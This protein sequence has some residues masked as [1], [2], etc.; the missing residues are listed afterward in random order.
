MHLPTIHPSIA[1]LWIASLAGAFWAGGE[2]MK[3]AGR[4][5][6]ETPPVAV[7]MLPAATS[8]NE[9]KQESSSV[10]V[11]AP[12]DPTGTLE[13]IAKA[14]RE[15]GPGSEAMH[16]PSTM[17]RTM[18]PLMDLPVSEILPALEEVAA[19]VEDP[20]QRAKL[21]SLLLGRWA[22]EDPLSALAY[23][24]KWVDE[25]DYAGTYSLASVVSTWANRDPDALWEWYAKRKESQSLP[26]GMHGMDGLT[27]PLEAIFS[28]TALRDPDLA[29]KQLSQLDDEGS[30]QA[31]LEGISMTVTDRQTWKAIL[32]GATTLEPE[33]RLKL[34]QSVLPQWAGAEPD[35]AI[36]WMRALP[37]DERAPLLDMIDYDLVKALPEKGADFLIENSDAPTLP[38]RYAT[39]ISAWASKDPAA[40]AE[41]LNRQPKSPAQDQARAT[42]AYAIMERDPESAMEW[43]KSISNESRRIESI[44]Q[45]YVW[46]HIGDA[47]AADA[48]LKSLSLPADK[49]EQI[50]QTT[51][52]NGVGG[53]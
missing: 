23:V 49:I 28:V 7:T 42:F 6:A 1:L 52:K 10:G 30:R 48:A 21:A 8:P 43:S 53:W 31:A 3:E 13:I 32:D 20:L 35:A 44:G 50:R 36:T 17:H 51:I 15:M 5:E 41:W 19:T 27:A 47:S 2:W 16:N 14:R 24:E 9:G 12:G 22:E 18:A 33:T 40:A 45:T 46:W 37:A 11:A 38:Q 29:I 34:R 4:V 26:N 25:G 39:V